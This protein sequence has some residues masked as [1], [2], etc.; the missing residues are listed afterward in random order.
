M[1]NPRTDPNVEVGD[2]D[3]PFVMPQNMHTRNRACTSPPASR[4]VTAQCTSP[5]DRS[6]HVIGFRPPRTQESVMIRLIIR[7]ERRGAPAF[8]VP[9]LAVATFVSPTLEPGPTAPHFIASR[10]TKQWG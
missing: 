7:L 3:S 8:A 5:V 10:D 1:T 9:V 6:L 4:K 2:A